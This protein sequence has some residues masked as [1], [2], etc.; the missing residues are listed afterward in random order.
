MIASFVLMFALPKPFTAT[1]T[2]PNS[3]IWDDVF[4]AVPA[5][6]PARMEH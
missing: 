1:L 3:W 6:Q 5:L 2:I 4:F